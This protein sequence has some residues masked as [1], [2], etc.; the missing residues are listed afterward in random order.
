MAKRL[1]VYPLIFLGVTVLAA[2]MLLPWAVERAFNQ[3]HAR[4]AY[5]PSARAQALL[6]KLTLADLH[7]DPLLW[8]R[9][10]NRRADFGH[11][12]I[13]RLIEGNV[14]LQVFG[15][16]TQTPFGINIEQN[17]DTT[18]MVTLLAVVSR[19]PVATW[20]NLTQRASY[21]AERL[22]GFAA[23]SN[24]RFTVI[25]TGAELDRHLERRRS[26]PAVTAGLL[27]LEG[28]HAFEGDLANVD[29][30]FDAGFRMMAPTHFFDTDIAGSAHGVAKGGLTDK[31]RE[32]IRRMEKRGIV[33]DLAHA[34]PRAI[35]EALSLVTRPV[36]F[37]HGGVRATCD[38]TRNLSDEQIR[39][40]ARTGGVIGIGVWETA[41]C[42]K[43]GRAIARAVRHVAD[44]AGVDHVALGSDFDGAVQAPF[45]TTGW[46]EVVDAL[47]A[48]GFDD[49]QIARITGG[50]VVRVLRA[51][52]P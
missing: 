10:L 32:M 52:L 41:V 14:A 50:N 31:G 48:E 1:L 37:S 12:D 19:W 9:D 17:D 34:S 49:V 24:G 2:M 11:V 23:A 28:A 33:L 27:A 47:V 13:P 39:G 21:M 51:T 18:D 3:L 35:E 43:D 29:V 46:V 40:I 45:D 22:R 5:Q 30:L 26:E 16:P 20:G 25:T 6:A 8:G 44:L 36:V 38:N 42:G 4:P 15:V 7:A